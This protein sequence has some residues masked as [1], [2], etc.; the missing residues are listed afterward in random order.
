MFEDVLTPTDAAFIGSFD[1][2]H[3]QFDQVVASMDCWKVKTGTDGEFDQ[4]SAYAQLL[5]RGL[6]NPGD[7]WSTSSTIRAASSSLISLTRA[8]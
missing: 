7:L 1:E 5:A 3:R 6:R 4:N 8:A 2:F